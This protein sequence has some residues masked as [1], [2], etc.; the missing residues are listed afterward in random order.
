LAIR[1]T[2]E[3]VRKPCW[4]TRTT[5]KLSGSV[6]TAS[7]LMVCAPFEFHTVSMVG[8]VTWIAEVRVRVDNA[9]VARSVWASIVSCVVCAVELCCVDV[10]LVLV[11]VI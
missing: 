1:V 3:L 2:G 6:D 4:L 11:L 10:V 8:L 5:I 9:R 7:Q